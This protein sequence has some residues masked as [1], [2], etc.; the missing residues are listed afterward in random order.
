MLDGRPL[1]DVHLHA[2]RRPTVKLD[3]QSTWL[4]G[5][6]SPAVDEVYDDAGT[7]RPAAFDRLLAAEGVD[8]AI[9]LSEYSPKVTG[10]QPVE[11]LL[12][13][14]AAATGFGSRP[15]STRTCTTRW[16]TSCNANSSSVRSH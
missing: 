5:F 8:I 2:A 14:A 1:I 12:P 15:I 10:Y 4:A 3:W 16:P 13:L 6:G 7:I 11:D 9:V